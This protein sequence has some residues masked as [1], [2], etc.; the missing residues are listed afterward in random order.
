MKGDNQLGAHLANSAESL[1]AGKSYGIRIEKLGGRQ[2][3]LHILSAG[4]CKSLLGS[5]LSA[6]TCLYDIIVAA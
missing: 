1:N 3:V 5:D 4:V 6:Q 2:D